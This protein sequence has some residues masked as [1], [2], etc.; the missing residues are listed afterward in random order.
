MS[1]L[2]APSGDATGPCYRCLFPEPP[3]P[4]TVPSCA[5]A[6]VLGVL[7]GVVGSLM[8]SEAI[9]ATVGLGEPLIGTLAHFTTR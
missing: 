2:H 9:K 7:P 5:E 4:G 3:P 1:L 8:A 6:G